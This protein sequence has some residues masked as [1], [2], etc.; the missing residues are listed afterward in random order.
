MIKKILFAFFLFTVSTASASAQ[1]TPEQSV[2]QARDQFF[3]IKKRSVEMER[4]KREAGKSPARKNVALKFSEIKEDFE[5]I[6]KLSNRLLQS[7]AV[8]APVNY[9]AVIK[10]VAE[11]KRRAVRLSSNLFLDEQAEQNAPK[12][13]R[14]GFSETETLETLVK[15]LDETI[16]RFAHNSMF[17][18]LN[19]VNSSDSLKAQKDLDAV[20]R[21]AAAIKAKAKTLARDGP[22]K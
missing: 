17:Q 10:S 8:K 22:E 11:I 1:R 2:L 4:T 16:D 15:I 21:L 19:L 7:D 3:D 5:N 6:Q 9:A 18:N 20:I 14:P 13:N 12:N